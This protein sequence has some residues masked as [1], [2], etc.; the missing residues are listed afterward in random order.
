MT[1]TE[2]TSKPGAGNKNFIRTATGGWNTCIQGNPTDRDCN[3]LANC[4]GGASGRFNEII[5]QVRGTSGCAYKT[6]NCNAE[7]FVE[8]ALAAGLKIGSTPK[9]GAIMCWQKGSLSS[10]DGAGHVAVVERVYSPTSVYTS[11]SGYGSKAFWN[12]TRNKGNGSWGLGGTYK[13]RCFIYLPDDVQAA[14]GTSLPESKPVVDNNK[15]I[16]E[17]AREVIAG[18]YGNGDAR[19]AALGSKY[20]EVQARV[21][22]ILAGN[23]PAPTPQPAQPS[24]DLLEA[25]KKTIRGDYGN[26]QARKDALGSHYSEVQNQVNKNLANGTTRWDNIKLY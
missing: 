4:V 8:R 24:F 7:N 25:V 22:E 2:R 10:S 21:N 17:L 9:V 1:F 6:L 23:Q 5:N 11:E 16:D 15:S 13:F 20:N 3:V 12:Q 26:G 18:K 14:I 19:K